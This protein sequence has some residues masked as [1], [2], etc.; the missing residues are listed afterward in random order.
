[1]KKVTF[2]LINFISI[3]ISAQQQKAITGEEF[4]QNPIFAGD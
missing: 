3:V 2:L 1:M 4:Y